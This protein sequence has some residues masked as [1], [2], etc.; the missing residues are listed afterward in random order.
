MLS[1]AVTA[2][3]LVAWS[4]SVSWTLQL[5]DIAAGFLCVLALIVGVSFIARTDVRADVMSA[6]LY[7]VSSIIHGFS[8]ALLKRLSMP[9]LALCDVYTH[10]ISQAAFGI[11]IRLSWH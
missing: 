10:C 8:R 2:F 9:D 3:L 1:R 6:H 7:N 11:L 4:L 5:D